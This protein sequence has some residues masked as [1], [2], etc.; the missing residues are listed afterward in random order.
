[1]VLGEPC[2]APGVAGASAP[3]GLKGRQP[4]M[5][6]VSSIVIISVIGSTGEGRSPQCS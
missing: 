5:R 1:M 4:H 6:A 2:H 3:S